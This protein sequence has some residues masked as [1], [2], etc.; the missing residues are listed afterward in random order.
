MN[1]FSLFTRQHSA[2][3][4]KRCFT[5][6]EL[7]V[8]IAIIAIL[9]AMLLPALNQ[10]RMRAQCTRCIGNLKQLAGCAQYYCNDYNDW[11]LPHALSYVHLRPS[12]G[13]SFGDAY[14]RT[15]PYQIWREAGY[16]PSWNEKTQISVLFCPSLP[17]TSTPYRRLYYGRVYGTSLGMSYATQKD[18]TTGLSKV[19]M[20]KL[21]QV[22][23]PAKKV[24][25]A[26][27]ISSNWKTSQY[28]I[29]ASGNPS[30]DGG[31]VWAHHSNVS[32]IANLT[33][34]V[35]SLKQ[36]GR[37]NT[38]VARH[39]SLAYDSDLDRRSRFFWGE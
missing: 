39:A 9:A 3:K 19:K 33:G 11:V 24:Y 29:G 35:Y 13:D 12:T 4:R 23:N 2:S 7:L 31:A 27:T 34:G 20:P 36:S 38:I 8:V 5:L 1:H 25:Q 37:R 18:L 21:A 14:I 10:A 30:G 32:N 6:I 17:D 22:R 28:L 26:D 16:I 15:A